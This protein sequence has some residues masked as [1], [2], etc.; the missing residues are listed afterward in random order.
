MTIAKLAVGALLLC[1]VPVLHA[2]DLDKPLLTRNGVSV[3]MRDVDAFMQRFPEDRKAG[4]LAS[5]KR[6]N[7]MLISIVSDKELAK[8][9]V[10]LKLDQD[11]QVKG[12]LAFVTNEVLARARSR[13]FEQ[14]LTV[15]SMS[16]AAK[17]EYAAHKAD[18][19]IPA[20]VE[21]QHVLIS[22]AGRNDTDAKALAEKVRSEALAKPDGFDELV[23]TYSDDPS[24]TANNGRIAEA[25]SP[26]MVPEFAHAASA[27]KTVGEISPVV[28]TKYGYHVLRL[29]KTS[30]SRQIPFAEAKD[31]IEAQLKTNYVT[32]QRKAWL[33]KFDVD[34]AEVDPAIIDLLSNRYQTANLPSIEEAA[35]GKPSN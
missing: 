35:K 25:A 21:V 11:P 18:Y 9:A 14:T 10:A 5:P 4:F 27:L 31:K 33:A 22:I 6:L 30:P 28:K 29:V 24:K 2:Q 15:P 7:Q 3:T 13:A 17:E 19:V 12:E 20:D 32:E 8:E 23:K 26:K 34:K 16:V 1:V